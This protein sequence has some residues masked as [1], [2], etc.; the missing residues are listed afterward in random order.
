M[1]EFLGLFGEVEALGELGD[2]VAGDV[3]GIYVSIHSIFCVSRKYACVLKL[4]FVSFPNASIMVS[5]SVIMAECPTRLALG[6]SVT[7]PV[8]LGVDHVNGREEVSNIAN[9][10]TA[11]RELGPTVPPN[12]T[13]LPSVVVTV[14]CPTLSSG[15]SC[16][17]CVVAVTN[18]HDSEFISNNPT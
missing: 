3:P 15:G 12:T 10:G 14:V 1:G 5:P 17:D 9:A 16:P 6:P 18:V 2:E 13:T 8:T 11:A 7:F 4:P